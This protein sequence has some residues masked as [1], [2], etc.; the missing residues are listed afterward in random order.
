[1][2]CYPLSMH[3]VMH[4]SWIG[5]NVI[6]KGGNIGYIEKSLILYRQHDNNVFGAHQIGVSIK[7]YVN[8]LKSMTYVYR[9]YRS[10]YL[11]AKS[12]LNNLTLWQFLFYRLIY[13]IRR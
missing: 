10:N 7:Y 3:A 4:D 5:L 8:K 1:M 2:L 12:I 6:A 11:M 13:L 9:N